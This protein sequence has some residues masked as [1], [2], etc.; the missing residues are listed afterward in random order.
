MTSKE[1]TYQYR[2][3]KWSELMKERT[4]L[5]Q[6]IRA[7]CAMKGFAENTYFYWQRRLRDAACKELAEQSSNTETGL[8]PTG[9]MQ[10]SPAENTPAEAPVTI[11]INGC[12][13][14]VTAETTPELLAKVCRTLKA[15]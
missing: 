4:E 14:A 5:G 3:A 10:L 6:S 2:L 11:E 7:Y 13:V 12:R 9:W 8:V 1:V 15:L